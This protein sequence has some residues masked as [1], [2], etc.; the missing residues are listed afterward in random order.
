MEHF[1]CLKFL[2]ILVD[3]LLAV[4]GLLRRSMPLQES[5]ELVLSPALF[6][7]LIVKCS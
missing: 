6:I 7:F 5:N 2:E 4:R 3:K 1:I